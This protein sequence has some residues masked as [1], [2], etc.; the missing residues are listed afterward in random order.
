MLAHPSSLRVPCVASPSFPLI[1]DHPPH[2][3]RPQP[4]ADDLHVPSRLRQRSRFVRVPVQS[5]RGLSRVCSV[6]MWSVPGRGVPVCGRGGKEVAETCTS[7][8][9]L[10]FH[11]DVSYL[12]RRDYPPPPTDL[13]PLHSHPRHLL[14]RALLCAST[15]PHLI[16]CLT[17]SAFERHPEVQYRAPLASR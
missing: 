10:L 17:P 2:F 15:L 3:P 6:W 7:T 14:R 9:A 16:P 8:F 11:L 4:A 12:T 5:V 1:L 13:L